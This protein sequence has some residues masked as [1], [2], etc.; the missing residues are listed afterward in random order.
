MT[1][2]FANSDSA[3]QR[4]GVLAEVFAPGTRVLLE[5]VKK[6]CP[7]V[8]DLGCG[9]GHTTHLLATALNCEQVV[10]LDASE[11][12]I[13]LA[14]KT[15]TSQVHFQVHDITK[16]PFPTGLADAL[17]CRFLLTHLANPIEVIAK[18]G[19]QLRP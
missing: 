3:A 11:H 9:P 19:T 10:G 2:L 18:W 17:F 7:L 12:F 4:L 8:V 16:V 14:R 1:Y 13:D 15:E 6:Q 5:Q